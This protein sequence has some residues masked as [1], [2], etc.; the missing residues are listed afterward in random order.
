MP[1]QMAD[2]ITFELNLYNLYNNEWRVGR[3][4]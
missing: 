3:K 2:N 4:L 1:F